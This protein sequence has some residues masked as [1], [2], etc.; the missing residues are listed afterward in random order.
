MARGHRDDHG[1]VKV[2]LVEFELEGSNSSIQESLRSF[3]AALRT[4][5]EQVIP[6]PAAPAPPAALE[7]PSPLSGETANTTETLIVQPGAE[8]TRAKQNSGTKPRSK[9]YRS[10]SIMELDL[11]SGEMSLKDF[12]DSKNPDSE[13]RKY[14]VIA[15]WLKQCRDISTVTP[16]HIHTCYRHMG[17]HTPRD[18]AQPLRDLKCKNQWFDKG[19]GIGE[20]KINHVGENEVMKMGI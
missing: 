19:A 9:T 6:L 20:Y 18:A 5:R 1:R 8:T 16:D 3:A 11:T 17:W 2:R 14:L 10:P 4:N 7:A 15:A 13:S 12:C